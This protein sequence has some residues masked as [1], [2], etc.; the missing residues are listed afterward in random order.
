[1]PTLASSG[2]GRAILILMIVLAWIVMLVWISARVQNFVRR[3]AGWRVQ[4][5]RNLL[6]SF[7]ALVTA[8]HLGNFAIDLFDRWI[9][10]GNYRLE[11]TFPGAFLCGSVAI[12]IGIAA[13]RSRARK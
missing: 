5:W 6:V 12:G 13:M 9:K 3:K 8:I 2:M 1:M 4:D 11:L 7:L 10:H